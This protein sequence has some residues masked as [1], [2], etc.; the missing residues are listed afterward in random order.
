MM[1]RLPAM[2]RVSLTRPSHTGRRVL[3]GTLGITSAIVWFL[4]AMSLWHARV[5]TSWLQNLLLL[6][7]GA[8]AFLVPCAGVWAIV[9]SYDWVRAMR[10]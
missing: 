3:A 2:A 7:G 9:H 1:T 8:I 5:P 6:S 10:R 4:I